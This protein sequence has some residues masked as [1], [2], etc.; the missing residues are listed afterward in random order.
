VKTPLPLRR[1]VI[2]LAGGR[3]EY[4]GLSQTGQEAQF[5]VDHIHPLADGGATALENL[6]LACVSCSLRKGARRKA[7]DP[8]MGKPALLFHPRKQRWSDHFQWKGCRVAGRT[9]TGRATVEA[10]KMNRLLAQCIRSEESLRGRHP[11]P[12]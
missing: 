4:C 2:R 6:A 9:P 3:C 10:L 12:A 5:H 7:P 8:L 11:P 1:A